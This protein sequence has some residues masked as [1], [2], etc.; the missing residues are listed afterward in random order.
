MCLFGRPQRSSLRALSVDDLVLSAFFDELAKIAEVRSESAAREM[1][2]SRPE[3]GGGT[4]KPPKQLSERTSNR[5]DVPQPV[6]PNMGDIKA[7][8]AAIAGTVPSP[9]PPIMAPPKPPVGEQVKSLARR[10]GVMIKNFEN[11][12]SKPMAP[13]RYAG[14]AYKHDY[15]GFKYS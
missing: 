4:L 14:T 12:L 13:H 7:Q 8:Q 1:R 10:G 11:I 6:V 5:M 9:E 2:S 3:A 15:S